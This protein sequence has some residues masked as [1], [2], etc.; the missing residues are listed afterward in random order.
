MSLEF[1][2]AMHLAILWILI[3]VR[4]YQQLLFES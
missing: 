2:F 4:R 3:F 1:L